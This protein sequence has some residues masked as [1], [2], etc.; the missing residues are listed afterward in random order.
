MTKTEKTVENQQQFMRE[1]MT[2]LSAN[3]EKTVENQQQIMSQ[4]MRLIENQQAQQ[5]TFEEH[6]TRFLENQQ[7]QQA[8][9]EENQ[10]RFLANQ[11]QIMNLLTER[12]NVLGSGRP[13]LII[14]PEA[15][16]EA[17]ARSGHESP[18]SC[19]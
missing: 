15:A 10:I 16:A 4:V 2:N 17:R 3:T 18:L 19:H 7:A 6:Q 9:F 14:N 5:A 13:Q 12:N 8:K 11:Q 1:M